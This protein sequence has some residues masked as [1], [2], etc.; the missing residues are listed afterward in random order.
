MKARLYFSILSLLGLGVGLLPLSQAQQ[1]L[2]RGF[3]PGEKQAMPAYLAAQLGYKGPALPY[4]PARP[5]RCMA[6]WEEV[7]YLV[8]AWTQYQPALREVVRHSQRTATVL[9]LCDDSL[10]VK[11][12]LHAGKVPLTRTRFLPGNFESVWIR[13]Y[14]PQSV[15]LHAVDSLFLVD[16]LYNRPRPADDQV[17]EWLAQELGLPLY[18]ASQAPFDLVHIGGNFMADGMGMAYSTELI[19]QENARPDHFNASPKTEADIDWLMENYLG[20]DHYLKLP[21]LP[22]NPI[23]H[24]DM[25]L[26][27][28]DEET[29]LVGTYPPGIADGPQIEANLQL[30]QQ[31][32]QILFGRPLQVVRIPMPQ[33]EGQYPDQPGAAYRTYTNSVFINELL[34]VPTY[35]SPYDTVALTLLRTALP[36]Y[37]IV[38][39]DARD[40][41][42]AGGALHCI[43]QTIGHPA[44]LLIAHRRLPDLPLGKEHVLVQAQIAHRSGIKEAFLAYQWPGDSSFRY[45]PLEPS[46]GKRDYWQVALP[47]PPVRGKVRYFFHAEAQDGKWQRR[48]MTAPEGYFRFEIGKE[49]LG[50]EPVDS[51]LPLLKLLR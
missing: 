10:A 48:P 18:S 45:L 32:H 7:G 51:I 20:I 24:L 49:S 26:K 14:G 41:I 34:L 25:H 19:L 8:L 9:I 27:L 28:L 11:R 3:A 44:P 22:Y 5:V 31:Q 35:A 23:H 4:P 42:R 38:G 43:T 15:Y 47:L 6:E 12:Y 16:Y 50:S 37:E 17:P 21:A 29:L 13:D 1:A 40:M 46:P 2:P 33:D 39:I 36:G 30:I